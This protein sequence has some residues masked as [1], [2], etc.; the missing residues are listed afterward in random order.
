MPTPCFISLNPLRPAVLRSLS[1]SFFVFLVS[2]VSF[3]S[4]ISLLNCHTFLVPFVFSCSVPFLRLYTLVG[5]LIFRLF[6]LPTLSQFHI[7]DFPPE[8]SHFLVGL[9]VTLFYRPNI[10]AALRLLNEIPSLVGSEEIDLAI[11]RSE[12][13]IAMNSKDIKRSLSSLRKIVVT[14]IP[15]LQPSDLSAWDESMNIRGRCLGRILLCY[16]A[17]CRYTSINRDFHYIPIRDDFSVDIIMHSIHYFLAKISAIFLEIKVSTVRNLA[18]QVVLKIF[19]QMAE[20]A[21]KVS[22][23]N[24][25]TKPYILSLC[26]NYLAWIRLQSGKDDKCIRAC[27]KGLTSLA[28]YDR[29]LSH[30]QMLRADLLSNKAIALMNRNHP[31]KAKKVYEEAKSL[32]ENLEDDKGM[33]AELE[34]AKLFD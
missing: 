4:V 22:S 28:K 9:V 11:M 17:Y 27:D 20:A 15:K 30:A 16:A 31:K 24:Y 8:Y 21:T 19:K 6:R 33:L 10:P 7:I 29:K 23:A 12:C 25:K 18:A 26:Y 3:Y 5:C 1:S 2:L 34:N 32:Y 13:E 14:K